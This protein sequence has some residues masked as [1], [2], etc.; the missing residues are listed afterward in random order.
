MPSLL[1]CIAVLSGCGGGG[2]TS[3][4][5]T[6]STPT[7]VTTPTACSLTAQTGGIASGALAQLNHYRN[8]TFAGASLSPL[9]FS[10]DANLTT[11]AGNHA[12]YLS[13][14]VSPSANVDPRAHDEVSTNPC[15]TGTT[16]S[17]RI[18]A[19]GNTDSMVGEDFSETSIATSVVSNDATLAANAGASIVDGLFNAVYHRMSLLSNF[20]NAGI[21]WQKSANPNLP[22][23]ILTID[24]SQHQANTYS[25]FITYPYS[26]QTDVLIDWLVD[27]NPCPL[28][29]SNT[30]ALAGFPI[31]IQTDGRALVI[32]SF[33]VKSAS[34]SVSGNVLT[35]TA[36]TYAA[37]ANLANEHDRA[38]F[39]PLAPLSP[40]TTY[41]VTVVGTTGGV[42]FTQTWTFTTL[43]ITAVQLTSTASTVAVGGTFDVT[44]SGGSQNYNSTSPLSWSS[45]NASGSSAVSLSYVQLASN[46]YRFTYNGN[47][48]LSSGCP[49]TFTGTDSQGNIGKVQVTVSP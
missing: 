28:G 29:C 9:L 18:A 19:T 34:G 20:T 8:V 48:T 14:L 17:A 37:D 47:C 30:G 39:V 12:N 11:A 32:S 42:A 40:N 22:P 44:F 4:T 24:L 1:A 38:A 15:F 21:A 46:S 10:A 5:T 33:T 26:G 23:T 7:P 13:L 45:V 41:T 49:V 25:N 2:G 3:T 36:G 6:V 31:T 16:V 27:E 35:A 43:P